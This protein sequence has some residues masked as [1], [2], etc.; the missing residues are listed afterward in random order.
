[1]IFKGRIIQII[2]V[3]DFEKY[4]FISLSNKIKKEYPNCDIGVIIDETEPA[5][6]IE[7]IE[8]IFIKDFREKS[9]FTLHNGVLVYPLKKP[10][11]FKINDI[12]NVNVL[13]KK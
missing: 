10:Y 3:K 6:I 9:F 5:N 13:V 2:K 8:R 12:V 11:K 1:M 4:F 7:R